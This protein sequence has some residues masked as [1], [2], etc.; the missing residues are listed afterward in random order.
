KQKISDYLLNFF[1]ASQEH[2]A[3]AALK[4]LLE[5]NLGNIAQAKVIPSVTLVYRLSNIDEFNVTL[6]PPGKKGTC[7]QGTYNNNQRFIAFRISP[8]TV[9]LLYR[10]D[11]K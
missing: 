6:V 10:E 2:G 9:W 8:S 7:V 3:G 1:Q 11:A 4:E 5:D